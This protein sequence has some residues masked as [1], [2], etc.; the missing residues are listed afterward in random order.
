MFEVLEY[1]AATF[2]KSNK[3]Y[4]D[5]LEVVSKLQAIKESPNVFDSLLKTIVHKAARLL[6]YYIHPQMSFCH[7][8]SHQYDRKKKNDINLQGKLN[9][10]VDKIITKNLYKPIETHIINAPIEIYLLDK[11]IPNKYKVDIRSHC[12]KMDTKQFL[13]NKQKWTLKAI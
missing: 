6:K 11:Y 5:N 4:G 10:Q 7:V 13:I 3:Y 1:Y 9:I 8:R 2:A 12:S